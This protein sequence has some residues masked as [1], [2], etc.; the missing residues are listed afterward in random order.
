[1]Q[2]VLSVIVAIPVRSVSIPE[3]KSLSV[4]GNLRLNIQLFTSMFSFGGLLQASLSQLTD[5]AADL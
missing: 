4:S 5:V 3:I 1:M 2:R